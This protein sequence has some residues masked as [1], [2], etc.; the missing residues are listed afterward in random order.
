VGT[1]FL[2]DG[3][4]RALLRV[5][6]DNTDLWLPTGA[7]PIGPGKAPRV[8]ARPYDN[9]TKSFF[10]LALPSVFRS[11]GGGQQNLDALFVGFAAHELA[12]T[13]Q[14][15]DVMTRIKKLRERHDVP[16]GIDDNFIQKT[17]GGNQQYARL[18]D[19][20][21]ARFLRAALK[22]SDPATSRRLLLQGLSIADRRRGRYFTGARAVHAELEDIFLVTEGV[23]EWVRFQIKRRQASPTSPW[24]QTLNEMMAESDAWSQQQGLVLFLLIDRFVPNA[25]RAST[26][27]VRRVTPDRAV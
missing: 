7:L 13:R 12:H 16:I 24:R 6:H 18:F 23:G 27:A 10:V 14:L 22:D 2:F 3:R 9:G 17:Y 25:S 19:E 4:P 5:P 11:L 8:F 15:V 26:E 21:R 20:E 1:S